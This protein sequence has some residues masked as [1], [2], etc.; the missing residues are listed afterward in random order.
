MIN[1][2]L[3]ILIADQ[4]LD[5]MLRIENLLN[6]F[7]YYRVAPLRSFDELESLTNS[8]CGSF[9]LLIV[10]KALALPCGVDL[11]AFCRARPH[12]RH[13]LFYES[14]DVSL[15]F[16]LAAATPPARVSIANPPDARSLGAL[17]NMIDPPS[18]WASLKS[19]QWLSAS[20]Q[21]SP[22]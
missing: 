13:V 16:A 3:R 2:A 8:P 14:P 11:H 22:I 17:M 18:Q 19:L 7:G 6:G 5:Q 12:I 21:A 15:E 1:K 4:H 10:N 9:D 20:G